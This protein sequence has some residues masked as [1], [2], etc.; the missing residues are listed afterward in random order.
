MTRSERALS[1]LAAG[2]LYLILASLA[3]CF[4]VPFAWML[5]TSLKAPN[6]IFSRVL[7]AV[8]RW[9]NFREIFAQPTLPFGRFFLNTAFLTVAC[10]ASSLFVSSI[11]AFAFARLRF[12]GRDVLF[13]CVLATMMVPGAVTMIPLFALF[14]RLGWIDTFL[15][16]LV[17]ALTGSAFQIFFLR[18][19]FKTIPTELF[20]AAQI[21]GCSNMRACL[22]IAVPLASPTLATLTIFSFLGYWNDFM[23]PLI[24]LHST[25]N[26]TL[27]LGLY[28]FSSVYGTQWHL[29]MAASTVAI[30]PILIVFFGCQRYIERGLVMSGIK[31]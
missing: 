3:F 13:V 9:S 17:P 30:I 19:F 6:E 18:Q 27:A 7:P 21:D 11:V 10:T 8:P 29:L 4:L 2:L 15:P 23:G 16:F 12:V 31:G 22:G 25:E 1:P 5:V 28:A 14:Q 26:R 20:E 24:Y